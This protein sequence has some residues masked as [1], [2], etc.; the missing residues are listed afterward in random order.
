M[1]RRDSM[2]TIKF[3]GKR[4]NGG[5]WVYGDLCHGENGTYIVYDS[6]FYEHISNT[7]KKIGLFIEAKKA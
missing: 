7:N 6:D 1:D 5:E 4:I 3:R 2:R